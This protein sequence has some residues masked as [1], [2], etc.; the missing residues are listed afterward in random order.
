MKKTAWVAGASGLIG[1]HLMTLL[2]QHSDY[3]KVIAFVR[4]P[5]DTPWS[6][7]PNVEQWCVDYQNLK[8]EQTTNKVDELYCALGSTTRKTPD[9]D[10]YYQIDV[11]YPLRFAELG[12]LHGAR[13]FGL[14]S[15]HGA[16]ASSNVSFYLKMKGQLEQSLEKLGYNDLTIARPSLLKGNRP[17]YRVVEKMSESLLSLMPGNYKAIESLDVAAALI[18][19]AQLQTGMTSYLNSKSMQKASLTIN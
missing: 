16:K 14:V 15:S 6:K 11:N 17:E 10:A 19:S 13:Y 3:E 1:G 8:A 12:L 7:H 2:S 18:K 9:K 5:V 4:K